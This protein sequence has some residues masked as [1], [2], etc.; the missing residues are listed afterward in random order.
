LTKPGVL[1]NRRYAKWA[2]DFGSA[3]IGGVLFEE[4]TVELRLEQLWRGYKAQ[5]YAGF[6][7]VSKGFDLES[8]PGAKNSVVSFGDEGELGFDGQTFENYHKGFRQGSKITICYTPSRSTTSST[9]A[10]A[11]AG[12]GAGGTLHWSIDSRKQK[13]VTGIDKEGK[14]VILCVYGQCSVV[15]NLK[16][17]NGKWG[18]NDGYDEKFGTDNSE[19]DEI[20]DGMGEEIYL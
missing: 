6:G 13:P 4:T 3:L 15:W 16:D 8:L 10:G 5:G 1:S 14:G 18:K 9:G 2:F 7:L 20:P 12:A 11:G 17:E 19:W